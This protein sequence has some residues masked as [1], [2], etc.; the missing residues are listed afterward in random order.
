MSERSRTHLV[1]PAV[2]TVALPVLYVLSVGPIE[3]L[4]A[5]GW[6]PLSTYDALD[7][8]YTP[9]EFLCDRSLWFR[10]FLVW[11]ESLWLS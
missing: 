3:W 8:F 5:K 1:V 4:D 2:A 11:Y 10:K 9:L 7:A 6:L